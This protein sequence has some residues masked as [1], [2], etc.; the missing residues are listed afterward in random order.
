MWLFGLT[1]VILPILKFIINHLSQ[2]HTIKQKNLELL[3]SAYKTEY[4]TKCDEFVIE[5]IISGIYRRHISFPIIQALLSSRSPIDSF[6][7]Y[8][9]VK[10]YIKL[11]NNSKPFRLK[12]KYNV[13]NILGYKLGYWVSVREFFCYFISMM[14]SFAL[15]ILAYN[16]TLNLQEINLE[17][18]PTLMLILF[19]FLVAFFLMVLG[20]YFLKIQG[21][22]RIVKRFLKLQ[23]T[24]T[25]PPR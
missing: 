25:T 5:H 14:V 3:L 15:C 23:S 21:N 1:I 24:H 17:N 4:M 11:N 2:K 7:T 8:K 20:L 12:K 9:R 6:E 13:I 16:M 22:I 19:V 10:Y 18:I